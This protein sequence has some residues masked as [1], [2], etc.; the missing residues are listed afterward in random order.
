MRTPGQC[1]VLNW[2]MPGLC[3]FLCATLTLTVFPEGRPAFSKQNRP[4]ARIQMLLHLRHDC[5]HHMDTLTHS[6]RHHRLSH[7][8]T[9]INCNPTFCT[10]PQCGN[11]LHNLL[12]KT[13]LPSQP[14]H[15]VDRPHAAK[16]AQNKEYATKIHTCNPHLLPRPCSTCTIAADDHVSTVKHGHSFRGQHATT[17]ALKRTTATHSRP[18]AGCRLRSGGY[19]GAQR[20]AHRDPLS[21][22]HLQGSHRCPSTHHSL[23]NHAMPHPA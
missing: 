2:S 6:V 23:Q 9:T 11:H 1:A 10:R 20:H 18:S 5:R 12:K 22:T 4:H 13:H 14:R 17:P 7:L 3:Y 19:N 15:C 8:K 21:P 16:C